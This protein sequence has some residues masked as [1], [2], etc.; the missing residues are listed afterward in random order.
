MESNYTIFSLNPVPIYVNYL[1]VNEQDVSNLRN[2]EYYRFSND[3][4]NGTINGR[5]LDLDFFQTLKLQLYSEVEKYVYDV[6]SVDRRI[7]VQF[8]NSWGVKNKKGDKGSY[9]NHVNSILSAVY[10]MDVDDKS[11]DIEFSYD[12][13][14]SNL[15][16]GLYSYPFYQWNTYNARQLI[17]KPKKGMIVIFPSHVYHS[18]YENESDIERLCISLNITLRGE[19]D[20][21]DPVRFRYSKVVL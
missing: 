20:L 18:V 8:E 7:K 17:I 21:E 14:Y 9:H 1:S 6:I 11:G 15:F 3:Y 2:E 13:K 10:Y 16:P 4:N 19:L 5:I 12:A